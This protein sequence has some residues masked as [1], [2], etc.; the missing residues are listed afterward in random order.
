[1][2][3]TT[4]RCSAGSAR[5]CWRPRRIARRRTDGKADTLDPA[6]EGR[7]RS[8][9]GAFQAVSRLALVAAIP[10]HSGEPR[11][12]WSNAGTEIANSARGSALSPAV[13]YWSKMGSLYAHGDVRASQAAVSVYRGWLA[14]SGLRREVSRAA[15]EASTHG[16]QP[17]LRAVPLY[18]LGLILLFAAGAD[19]S[20]GGTP[21][22]R[23]A[24]PVNQ[25]AV[26]LV[27]LGFALHTTGLVFAFTLAGLPPFLV[28]AGW[29]I[30]LCGLLIEC[31]SR[32][33]LGVAVAGIAALTALGAI[34]ALVPGGSAQFVQNLLD[35]RLLAAI[36][37][38]GA[39][40]VAAARPFAKQ[41][42][43]P[44]RWVRVT[45]QA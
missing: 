30:A 36:A 10:L 14:S 2:R 28:F 27:A 6:T 21:T 33:G 31:F 5:T 24:R 25:S 23:R 41:A 40:L 19:A 44:A 37:A 15:W 8:F 35:V 12:R 38:A 7:I 9:A 32:R 20:T 45:T 16:L 22:R 43:S 26:L 1:M 17:M 13:G 4:R 3:S 29:T 34:Y 18:I 11:S 39:A 42:D